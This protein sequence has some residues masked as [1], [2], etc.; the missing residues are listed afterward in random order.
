MFDNNRFGDSKV[1][2]AKLKFLDAAMAQ[3]PNLKKLIND[4]DSGWPEFLSIITTYITACKKLKATTA[5]DTATDKTI[6]Q[7][8]YLDHEIFILTSLVVNGPGQFIKKTE[9]VA[10][11]VKDIEEQEQIAA[12]NLDEI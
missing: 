4:E 1:K 7:L 8:K 10:K 9:K 11:D 2:K 12:E 3:V 6:E 5:L